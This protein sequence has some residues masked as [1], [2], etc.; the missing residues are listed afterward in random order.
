TFVEYDVPKETDINLDLSLFKQILK[1]AKSSDI[2]ILELEDNR[3][4]ITMRSATTKTYYLPLLDF[5]EKVQ[6]VPNLTFAG[7]ITLA[8]QHLAEAI[9]DADIIAESVAFLLSKEK[10]TI[11]AEADMSKARIEIPSDE[12]TKIEYTGKETLKAR[13]SIEYLKKMIAATKLASVATVQF[14]NDY[15]LRME[16]K[17]IDR[18]VMTFILAPRVDND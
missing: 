10:L 8:S 4:K 2:L 18:L 9:E 14:S 13:Y 7:S 15:P 11:E 17:D 6:K 5:E 12:K 3:F 1:R 16:F